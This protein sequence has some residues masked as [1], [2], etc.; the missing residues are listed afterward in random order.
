MPRKHVKEIIAHELA[1]V[2]Q[3]ATDDLPRPGSMD[4]TIPRNFD[5]IENIA[6]EYMEWW[7]FDPDAIDDWVNDKWKWE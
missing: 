4:K 7:G 5:P 1:H 3:Y 6:D 2:V